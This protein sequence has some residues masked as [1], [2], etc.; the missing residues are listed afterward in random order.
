MLQIAAFTLLLLGGA[1]FAVAQ[2]VARLDRL[3]AEEYSRLKEKTGVVLLAINWNRR[4]NCGGFQNAQLQSIAFDRM[5]AAARADDAPPDLRIADAP[6]I[7][8]TPGFDNYAFVVDPGS[9]VLSG[10]EV[11]A[12]MSMVDVRRGGAGRSR[13]IKDG[14]ALGGSF[15]VQAREAVY[16]G[17]FFLDCYQQPMLW[18]FYS[19]GQEEFR[20]YLDSIKS[21]FPALD[22]QSIQYRPMTTVQF[23]NDIFL[24]EGLKAERSKDWRLAEDYYR[25]DLAAWSI[26]AAPDPERSMAMYNL[27]RIEGYL[28]KFGEAETLLSDSLKLQESIGGPDTGLVTKRLLELGR[29]FFDRRNYG[30]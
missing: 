19:D 10:F 29:L 17:H 11:K 6:L 21:K 9:Y 4:W 1:R 8:T 24:E 18:R 7:M 28:C 30:P 14:K 25:R 5:A 16:I 12:A 27:G 3:S 26:P 22:M 13:L 23:G 2:G 20:K 15:E